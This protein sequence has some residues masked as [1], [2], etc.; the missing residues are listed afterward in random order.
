MALLVQRKVNFIKDQLQRGDGSD[1]MY[2]T[3]VTQILLEEELSFCVLG[4][5]NATDRRRD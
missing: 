4:Q 3:H 1:V 2:V 5:P